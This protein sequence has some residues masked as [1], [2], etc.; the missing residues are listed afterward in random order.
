MSKHRELAV[1]WSIGSF[2]YGL[3]EILWRGYTHWSML[4]TG[5]VCFRSIYALNKRIRS[6]CIFKKCFLF[7][8]VITGWE[9][10]SGCIFNKALKLSVWDY[11]NRPGNLLGQICPLYSLLWFFLG[12]PLVFLCNVLKSKCVPSKCVELKHK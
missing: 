2:G 6:K 8:C 5:G 7:S 9:F 3:L 12:F 10:I 1:V 11:S 4:L